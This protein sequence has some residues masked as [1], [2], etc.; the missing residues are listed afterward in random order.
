MGGP[1]GVSAGYVTRLWGTCPCGA[2]TS[3]LLTRDSLR[4]R[5]RLGAL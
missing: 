4:D 5:S 1:G 3:A 2:S